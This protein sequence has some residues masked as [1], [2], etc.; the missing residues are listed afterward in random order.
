MGT[1][2]VSPPNYNDVTAKGSDNETM[3]ISIYEEEKA[4][5]I[6]TLVA[7]DEWTDA[8]DAEALAR[9]S[10]SPNHLFGKE[11]KEATGEKGTAP[12]EQGAEGT[13][14]YENTTVDLTAAENSPNKKRSKS[15]E[16][17]SW[18]KTSNL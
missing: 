2:T 14:I 5:T 17:L 7:Y 12:T 10:I 3:T 8:E 11:C 9:H 6:H 1:V 16:A 13:K 15:T 18:M 4:E